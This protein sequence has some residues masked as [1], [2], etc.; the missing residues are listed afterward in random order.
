MIDGK[1]RHSLRFGQPHV[2][3]DPTPTLFAWFPGSP[4]G[5][6]ATYG[7]EMKLQ[8]FASDVGSGRTPDIDAFAFK[9]IGPKD[10]VPAAYGAIARS[11]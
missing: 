1:L 8:R 3:G 9:V 7:T 2:D 10:P 11:N 5:H 4:I 6:A